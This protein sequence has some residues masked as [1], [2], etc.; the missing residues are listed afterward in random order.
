VPEA[1]NSVPGDAVNGLIARRVAD[2]RKA[3]NLSFDALAARSEISKGMVVAIEQGR[4]NP[5]I[6]TL[7]K[8]AAA[9][10]V[11]LAE[12]L[13]DAPR[14]FDPVRVVAP[15][16]ASVLWEGAKGGLATLL[17]GST[18]PDMLELWE[19]TLFPGETFQ[20]K[21]HPKGT[22]ELLSV[23]EGTLALEVDGIDYLVPAHHRAVAKTDRPHS[24]RC[25]GGKRTRFSMVVHDPG[26]T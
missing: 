2:L 18:G 16:Q 24:Y 13:A 4:A 22:V 14:T 21:R 6:G 23:K 15:D 26:S 10:H 9:L 1:A 19:W 25:H 11:S 20:S 8:L 3:R 17:V 5:S 7:C 12:L